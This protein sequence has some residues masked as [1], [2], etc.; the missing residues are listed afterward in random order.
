MA[1]HDAILPFVPLPDGG[2]IRVHT[3]MPVQPGGVLLQFNPV[4][5]DVSGRVRTGRGAERARTTADRRPGVIAVTVAV[6]VAGVV[7]P[8]LA[9]V[10]DLGLTRVLSGRARDAADAGALAAAA[11]APG[12]GDTAGAT[13]AVK[14]AQDAV[15]ANVTAPDDMTWSEA[16]SA[17][18]DPSP[19]PIGTVP[20]PGNC[21]SFDLALKQVRVTVP[22]RRVPTVFAGVLGASPP[23]ASA[24]STASWGVKVT[25]AVGSCALCV[26]DSYSGGI[27]STTVAGGDAAIGDTLRVLRYGAL[28]VTGGG[29]TYANSWFPG[30]TILPLP[31]RRPAPVDPYASSLLGLLTVNGQPAYGQAS[32][33]VP[34]GSTCHPGI[35]QSI[36]GCDAFTPG[37][38]V[39]TGV[40]SATAQMSLNADAADVVLVFTCSAYNSAGVVAAACPSGLPPKFNGSGKG[41]HQLTAPGG[42]GLALVFDKGLAR[43][44]QL[45]GSAQL[46]VTGDVYGPNVTLRDG[47]GGIGVVHG[48]VVVGAVYYSRF[49]TP[50]RTVLSVDL[51]PV[52]TQPM[53]DGP[54]RLVRSQ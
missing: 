21:V 32:A 37:T 10:V 11:L 27:E 28:R 36:N 17:C 6:V 33:A 14:A 41:S 22:Q 50:G 29:V 45:D 25:P 4:A 15:A 18:V 7:L 51:P 42:S 54:V 44:E 30:G 13:A 49:T 1:D 31:V 20:S 3:D 23:V 9:L 47:L 40:P 43:K 46:T 19:L 2:L 48:H 8:L 26:L 35:V 16:W 24:T 39:I 5:Q 38:Y 53:A 52:S 34:D 12:V